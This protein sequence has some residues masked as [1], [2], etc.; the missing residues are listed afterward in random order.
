MV[1]NWEAR[2]C[3]RPT[4]RIYINMEGGLCRRPHCV[5]KGSPTEREAPWQLH[6]KIHGGRSMPEAML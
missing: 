1:Y 3:G 4:T 6:I 2:Q 5:Y